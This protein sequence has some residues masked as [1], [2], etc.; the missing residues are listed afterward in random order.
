MTQGRTGGPALVYWHEEG[1]SPADALT[2]LDATT[3]SMIVTS[4]GIVAAPYTNVV[5]PT[6][7]WR[8]TEGTQDSLLMDEIIGCAALRGVSAHMIYSIGL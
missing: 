6:M 7:P 8:L 2:V 4:G 5:D 3:I 1:G